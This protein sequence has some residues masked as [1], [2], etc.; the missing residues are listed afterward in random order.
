MVQINQLS[1]ASDISGGDLIPVFKTSQGDA[2]K[3]S[4][5]TLLD[6]INENATASNRQVTQYASPGANGFSVTVSQGNVWL[7]LT[8]AAGYSSGGV[9]L[10]GAPSDRDTVTVTSTQAVTSLA[11]TSTKSVI[12]EPTA[13]AANGFFTMRYDGVNGAWYRI[14]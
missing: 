9:V 10:P 14:G 11:V 5:T 8:P 13:I 3:L 7:L 4:F 6:W 12:G 1:S 2:R